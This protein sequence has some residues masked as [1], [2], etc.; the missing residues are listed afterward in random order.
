M[1]GKHKNK[2]KVIL[3]IILVVLAVIVI[4]NTKMEENISKGFETVDVICVNSSCGSI[5]TADRQ[6][7]SN[8]LMEQQRIIPLKHED[9]NAGTGLIPKRKIPT[10]ICS[11]CG[12][13]SAQTALK[14]GNCGKVFLPDY[15]SMHYDKCPTCC[16]Q[17]IRDRL[18]KSKK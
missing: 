15:T 8:K 9:S 12:E 1:Y 13:K 7:V 16:H 11:K 17:E 6:E 2:L 3:A 18:D 14:C 5:Y 4:I 10:F